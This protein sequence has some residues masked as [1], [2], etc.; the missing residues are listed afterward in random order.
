MAL[1]G[2]SI[3]ASVAAAEAKRNGAITA[4]AAVA[5]RESWRSG[6]MASAI[7]MMARKWRLKQKPPA[8]AAHHGAYQKR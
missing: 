2:I 1:S 7:T 5:L 3:Q 6:V 4:A 8:S